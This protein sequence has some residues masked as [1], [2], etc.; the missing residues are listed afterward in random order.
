MDGVWLVFSVC[1]MGSPQQCMQVNG[2]QFLSMQS[3]SIEAQSTI[4]AW[5]RR[6]PEYETFKNVRCQREPPDEDEDLE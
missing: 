2:G 1:M 5:M 6:H 3:C 4:S